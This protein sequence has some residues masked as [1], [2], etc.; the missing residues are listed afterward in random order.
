MWWRNIWMVPKVPLFCW[1]NHFLRLGQKFFVRLWKNRRQRNFLLR[2]SDLYLVNHV[3]VPLHLRYFSLEIFW[4]WEFLCYNEF[5]LHGLGCAVHTDAFFY[6]FKEVVSTDKKFAWIF[7]KTQV[8]FMSLFAYTFWR[9]WER[10]MTL[11][12]NI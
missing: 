11:L 6:N 5:T 12:S 2:F 10:N 8:D 3:S 7:E 4:L 9:Y 1:F